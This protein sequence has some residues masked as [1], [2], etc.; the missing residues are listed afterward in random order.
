MSS[1][2]SPQKLL[3]TPEPANE[4][5][6]DIHRRR[7]DAILAARPQ[8]KNLTGACRGVA[9]LAVLLVAAQ[10]S[11]AV[12]LA[13]LPLV[14]TIPAAI[15]VGAFMAHALN[16]MIH[17]ASHNLVLSGSAANKAIAILANLPGIVPAAM[18]FR[19]YHLLHHAHLGELRKDPDLPLPWEIRRVGS[20]RWRK[21][22]WLLCLPLLYGALH[23]A[24][25]R[26]RLRIDGWLVANTVVTVG[27]AVAMFA[28]FGIA[29]LVYL[30]LSVYFAV[31]PHPTGAHILQEHIIFAPEP[32]ETASYY[33]PINAISLNHGYHTEH[34]DFPNVPGPRLRRLH[35]A[36]RDFYE[37][38]FIHRSRLLTLWQFVFGSSNAVDRRMTVIRP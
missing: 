22:A 16:V 1:T 38:R 14:W 24:P 33:G 19:H 2:A 23:P 5:P 6:V 29:P 17:E 35:E 11:V 30:G 37:P 9:V 18:P 26:P 7:R 27:S 21:L 10:C 4:Y 15:F 28:F 12:A 8:I 20:L 34:H 32:Y 36:A 31:G 25:V 3:A 13:D